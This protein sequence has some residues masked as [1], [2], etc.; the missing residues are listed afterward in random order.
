MSADGM[1]KEH[2]VINSAAQWEHTLE[3]LL[4]THDV[5][6]GQP[7]LPFPPG[8][9]NCDDCDTSLR[10]LFVVNFCKVVQRFPNQPQK[11]PM[12]VFCLGL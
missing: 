5:V 3:W 10:E 12:E 9:D 8:V 4:G 11:T 2:L 6:H 1:L 7:A